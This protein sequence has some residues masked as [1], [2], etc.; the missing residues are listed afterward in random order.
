[1]ACIVRVNR[2]GYLAYRLRWAGMESHEGTGLADTPENRRKVEARAQVIS[3]EIEAGTFNYLRWFPHGNKVDLVRPKAEAAPVGVREYAERWLPQKSSGFVRK[4]R[5]RDYRRH[6]K[7]I[8]PVVGDLLLADVRLTVLERLRHRLHER[9]L[10]VKTIRNIVDGTF[11]ALY[12]DARREGLVDSDPFIGLEWPRLPG[13]APDPYTEEE[14]DELLNYFRGRKRLYYPFVL[15]AFWTG[16]R[17][18]ELVGLRWGD[19]DLRAG[20]LL[21]RRSRTFGEDN[22]PKTRGSERTIDLAPFVVDVLRAEKPLHVRD[23]DFVFLNPEARP[24]DVKVFTQWTWNPALRRLNLRPRKFYATR[25]TFISVALTRGWN[26]KALAEYCGTSVAMIERHYG[27]YLAGDM[28]AQ[29]RLLGAPRSG[30][31]TGNL[32]VRARQ[33]RDLS[34]GEGGIRTLG[35]GTTPTHA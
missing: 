9:G 24:I 27:R 14:R 30:N 3:D 8:L 31:L 6:L 25:H 32:R 28:Q 4:S 26:L 22:A 33:V 12:R 20:K 35:R 17:P 2:H 21:I 11:R 10:S 15:T 7:H 29:L 18:S 34:S 19:V 23:D 5:V 1:M 13:R 16:A